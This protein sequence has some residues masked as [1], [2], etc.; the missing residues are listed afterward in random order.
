MG[1]LAGKNILITGGNSG[2]GLAAA[3]ER[4]D[5]GGVG[6]SPGALLLV[7]GL[8][9]VFGLLDPGHAAARALP[10]KTLPAGT[11]I[12]DREADAVVIGMADDDNAAG[13]KVATQALI[14]AGHCQARA[15]PTKVILMPVLGHGSYPVDEVRMLDDQHRSYWIAP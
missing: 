9:A 10:T 12:C 7:A 3:Q 4:R 6:M 2:I 14:T 15:K 13:G 5:R 8:A 1:K 11:V